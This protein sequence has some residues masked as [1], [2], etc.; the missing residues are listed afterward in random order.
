MK[1]KIVFAIL[2]SVLVLG[3]ATGCGSKSS[4]DDKTNESTQNATKGN[5][6]V[7]EC[8]KQVESDITVEEINQIIGVEGELSKDEESYTVY[9]WELTEDT[10][11]TAQYSKST[12]KATISANYPNKIITEKADFSRYDEI[13]AALKTKDSLTYEQFVEIVGGV[14]GVLVQKTAYSLSYKWINAEGGYLSGYF[15]PTTGKCTMATGRF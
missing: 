8:M 4:N 7:F 3:V 13:A 15:N 2:C 5:C 1:K 6:T 9:T 12:K 14:E 11:I 10:S